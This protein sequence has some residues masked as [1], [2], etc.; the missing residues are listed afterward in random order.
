M[1]STVPSKAALPQQELT[2]PQHDADAACACATPSMT[3]RAAAPYLSRTVAA[4]C[5][6]ASGS[7]CGGA[8]IVAF[9]PPQQPVSQQAAESASCCI[10]S[11][12]ITSS[13]KKS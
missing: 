10:G 7:P 9:S 2:G 3:R 12:V 6:P 4:S 13:I 8:A 11:V 5:S 1:G